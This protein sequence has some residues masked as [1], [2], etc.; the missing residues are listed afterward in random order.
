MT[1]EALFGLSIL[2]SL[3][4]YT[5]VAAIYVWPWLRTM[6]REDAFKVLAVPH[7]FRFVGLSF[8]IPGVV[9]PSLSSEFA[10]PAA[11]GDLGATLLAFLAV[12]ALSVRT[13]LATP[14]LWL[15][16]LWGSIDLANA[17]YQGQ[18][19]GIGPGTL[20]AA[21]FIPTVIVPGL[22]VAHAMMLWL[23]LQPKLRAAAAG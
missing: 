7:L 4:A 12:A 15:L 3:A 14:I 5:V 20:G 9:S 17:I 2:V 10:V 16:T 19:N 6:P 8:L 22:L 13:F 21:Y 1:S 18:V 23:L 11:Y